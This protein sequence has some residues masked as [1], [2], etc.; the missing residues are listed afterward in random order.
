[1][2][3]AKVR[4]EP[5]QTMQRFLSVLSFNIKRIVR[6]HQYGDVQDLLHQ[7][8]EAELQLAED[9]KY[10][11]RS[12]YGRGSVSSRATPSVVPS[13]PASSFRGAAPS[14]SASVAPNAKPSPQPAASAAGSSNFTARTRDMNCHTCGGKGHFKRECPNKKVMLINEETGEYESGD[15]IDPNTEFEEDNEDDLHYADAERLPSIVCT[16][17]VLSVPPSSSDQRCNLFQTR[18][19]MDVLAK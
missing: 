18:A 11:P 10:A 1:M 8:R 19:A 17:K 15:E 4:E 2:Q 14:K 13:S 6:H 3:R 5:E 12:S 9:A 7:A 16:P